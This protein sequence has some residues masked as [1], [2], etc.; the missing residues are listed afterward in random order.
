M[1]MSIICNMSFFQISDVF[2]KTPGKNE[3]DFFSVDAYYPVQHCRLVVA[4]RVGGPLEGTTL[5]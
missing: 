3:R 2:L 4:C 5:L 1:M